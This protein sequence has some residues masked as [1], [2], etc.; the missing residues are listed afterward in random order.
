MIALL[1]CIVLILL[2][3][4]IYQFQQKKIR[5]KNLSYITKNLERITSSR[6]K[7]R[8]LIVSDDRHLVELLVQLNQLLDENQERS[9]RFIRMEASMKRMLANISHDLKTP[10]T[11]IAGYTEMLQ[12]RSQIDV[13]ERARLLQHVHDKTIE[14]ITLMNSFFDLAKLESGDKEIPLDKVNLTEI[15]KKNILAFYDWIQ[16]KELEAVIEIPEK[17]IFA[18]GNEE[19]LNRVLN[20]LISNSLRYG[21]EGK[22]I[23]LKLFY[24]EKHVNVEVSDHG[25]GI[26][27]TE[28]E[29]V[30]ERMFTL[31][32]SRNKA[33]QGSGL[34]LTITKR[35]IEEMQGD[36]S[37]KSKPFE[38]TSFTFSL[39][40][41]N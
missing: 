23:G 17:P 6:S 32:E 10:L 22:M 27:E 4:T 41:L 2:I 20:N 24:D 26:N 16:T 19:A 21:A 39:Q 37:V 8:L 36:I 18:F 13:E 5:N 14:L 38:K 25:K 1:G 33:F 3:C 15:C 35:L 11:V 34:G 7:E 31:E 28:Q 9:R 30:F 12:S 40:R 29:N